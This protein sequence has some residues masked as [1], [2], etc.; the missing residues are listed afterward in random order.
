MRTKENKELLKALKDNMK[1]ID[2]QILEKQAGKKLYTEGEM[3]ELFVLD[4]KQTVPYI[5]GKRKDNKQPVVLLKYSKSP[6]NEQLYF[7]H[8][9]GR[10]ASRVRDRYSAAKRR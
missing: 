4:E 10:D 9:E 5:R 1:A 7:V 8:A 2:R 3:S 6:E